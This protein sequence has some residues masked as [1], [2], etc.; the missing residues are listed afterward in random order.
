MPEMKENL[1][2]SIEFSN[3]QIA[4]D[5]LQSMHSFNVFS[6][7][8]M[9]PIDAKHF[10]TKPRRNLDKIDLFANI[11]DEES[12]LNAESDEEETDT[13]NTS[14]SIFAEE[15]D[16]TP[17]LEEFIKQEPVS[18]RNSNV[19]LSLAKKR[20]VST[21][22]NVFKFYISNMDCW[23]LLGSSSKTTHAQKTQLQD[24]FPRSF[25]W[26]LE[27][28]AQT[29]GV[30]WHAVFEQ[31]MC[32]ETMLCLGINDPKT[33]KNC[34]YSSSHNQNKHLQLIINNFREIW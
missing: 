7:N 18:P 9:E 28:C 25:N 15:C 6:E 13:L 5:E 16:L 19:N 1:N 20:N 17:V 8:N 11:S 2:K 3:K 29:I 33:I 12:V 31:L 14:E 24:K 32:L 21:N 30:E 34:V 4:E 27:T 10:I 23:M 26:L 22:N